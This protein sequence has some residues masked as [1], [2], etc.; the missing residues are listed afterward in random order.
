MD[1]VTYT[2]VSELLYSH[3]CL[4]YGGTEYVSEISV[5]T[6]VS[7]SGRREQVIVP[8]CYCVAD[9]FKPRLEEDDY[10]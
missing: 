4:R 3:P 9:T 10:A 5:R 2:H 1:T 7:P 8:G 6:Y